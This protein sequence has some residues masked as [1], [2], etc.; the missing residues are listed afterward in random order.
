MDRNTLF[1]FFLISLVLI[2]T[3]RYMEIVSPPSPEPETLDSLYTKTPPPEKENPGPRPTELKP[4]ETSSYPTS[5]PVPERVVVINTELYSAE[6]SSLNG[7]SFKSFKFN[8][9]FKPDSQLVDIVQGENLYINGKTLD[10]DPL[11]LSGSWDMVSHDKGLNQRV[12]FKKEVFSCSKFFDE[13]IY[14]I[15]LIIVFVFDI[16]KRQFII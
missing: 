6:V 12:V 4:K 2:L 8:R 13:L 5:S 15:I 9:Y 10:G 11:S 1:A 16:L 14:L 7:G 3:P